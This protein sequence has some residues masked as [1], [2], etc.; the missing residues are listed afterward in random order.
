MEARFLE[1]NRRPKDEHSSLQ[2][3]SNLSPRANLHNVP[4][5]I[6]FYVTL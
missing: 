3:L 5:F 2:M 4:L 6:D 1:L